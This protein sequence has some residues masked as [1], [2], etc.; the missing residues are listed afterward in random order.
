MTV[1]TQFVPKQRI[2][3]GKKDGK[4]VD[5]AKVEAKKQRQTLKA[6]KV[7]SFV[8]FETHNPI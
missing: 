1:M 8:S 4:K 2:N 7:M 5:K 6:D 3:M